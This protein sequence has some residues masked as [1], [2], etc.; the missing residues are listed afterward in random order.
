MSHC[1][2]W[3]DERETVLRPLARSA[4]CLICLMTAK[5]T[6]ADEPSN[7]PSASGPRRLTDEDRESLPPE[8]QVLIPLHKQ[9][10]APQPNDWL[11]RHEETAETYRQFLAA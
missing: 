11:D 2:P 3:R 10:G 4:I 5:L 7:A 9:L 1:S 6:A 8:L